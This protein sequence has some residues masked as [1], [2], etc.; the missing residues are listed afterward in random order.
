MSIL[1]CCLRSVYEL[2][3][4]IHCVYLHKASGI[5]QVHYEADT[6]GPTADA[7]KSPHVPDDNHCLPRNVMFNIHLSSDSVQTSDIQT[8]ADE[9]RNQGFG[10]LWVER[11]TTTMRNEDGH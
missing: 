4:L 11:K 5:G 9:F 3:S 10:I 2:N 7:A 8:A 1:P 6:L